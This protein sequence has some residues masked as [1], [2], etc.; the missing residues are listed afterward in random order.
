MSNI[1]GPIVGAQT[2]L[3]MVLDNDCNPPNPFVIDLCCKQLSFK[4]ERVVSGYWNGER[5]IHGS[6]IFTDLMVES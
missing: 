1:S 4:W 3:S 6:Y 5:W 2:I